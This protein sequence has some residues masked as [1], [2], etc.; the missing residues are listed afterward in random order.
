MTL[1]TMMCNKGYTEEVVICKLLPCLCAPWCILHKMNGRKKDRISQY[2][3][4]H[5]Q[6]V[7]VINQELEAAT[8]K[9]GQ[10]I[11]WDHS[12]KFD[13]IHCHIQEKI[14]RDGIHLSAGGQYQL[15]KSLRGALASAANRLH[16]RYV[17]I[18]KDG[19]LVIA[20]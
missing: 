9:L 15:Y 14:G 5:S 16:N 19:F 1:A 13:A 20:L 8:K 6:Q 18:H 12:G 11:F 4:L 3:V 7:S 2:L 17:C 10:V